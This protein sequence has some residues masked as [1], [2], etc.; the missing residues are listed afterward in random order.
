MPATLADAGRTLA[1]VGRRFYARNWVLGTS[2][3]FSMVLSETPLRLA[4][5]PSAAHKGSLTG[6]E[7]LEVDASGAVVGPRSGR[8]S[9]ETRLHLEVVRSRGASAVLHTHSVW[10]TILSHR[11]ADER[12]LVLEG[13][14]MLKGLDGVVTHEHREWVPIVDND[15]D[16]GRLAADVAATLGRHPQSHGFLLRGHG[17]YTW[18]ASIADAERHVEI[19]EFLLEV[20]GRTGGRSTPWP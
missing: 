10:G 4:I 17:L 18:G 2:G 20:T 14:E 12:G 13:F 3:N 1:E 6:E 7:F 15:Q 5:T 19:F 9:A 16:M 8:P 11:Y